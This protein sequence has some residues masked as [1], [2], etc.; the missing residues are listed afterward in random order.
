MDAETPPP[1]LPY[2]RSDMV[3]LHLSMKISLL[4][5]CLV[6]ILQAGAQTARSPL[7]TDTTARRS[8]VFEPGLLFDRP[9]SVPP[10]EPVF[11]PRYFPGFYHP[12]AIGPH[13][14]RFNNLQETPDLLSPW[15][16]ELAKQDELST[17]R[18]ILGSVG[19]GGAAYIAYRHVKKYGFW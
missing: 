3:H 7:A 15:K 2:H 17:M 10:P 18:M 8:T 16:L 5:C 6:F 4:I 14:F 9:F 13:P 11:I 12:L 1:A 19:V